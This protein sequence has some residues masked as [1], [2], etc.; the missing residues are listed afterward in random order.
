[1][2]VDIILSSRHLELD[3]S[4]QAVLTL[5]AIFA[6][7]PP[8]ILALYKVPPPSLRSAPTPKISS[9]L[10]PPT[11]YS[12]PTILT[13]P[14]PLFKSAIMAK[15]NPSRRWSCRSVGCGAKGKVRKNWIM[16][17]FQKCMQCSKT[18]LAVKKHIW[19]NLYLKTKSHQ[20]A[21]CSS[22]TKPKP[23]IKQNQSKASLRWQ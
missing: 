14:L 20:K 21:V 12:P 18:K 23:Q 4:L 1:M 15:F 5:K 10:D 3:Q 8:S 13:N 9:T 2:S 17:S 6:S 16:R 7:I 11:A 22:A 19:S